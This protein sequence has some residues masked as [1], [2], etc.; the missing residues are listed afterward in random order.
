MRYRAPPPE[1]LLTADLDAFAAV[2][3]RPSG[4]THLLASPAREILAAL[5]DAPLDLDGVLAALSDR[6]DIAD[7]SRAALAA[8][9][10]ELVGVGLVEAA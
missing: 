9:L 3:H 2:F 6:F 10:D 5:V 7:A 1:A 8:R 4:I